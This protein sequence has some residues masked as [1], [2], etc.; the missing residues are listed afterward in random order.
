VKLQEAILKNLKKARL[1]GSKAKTLA[2]ITAK[3]RTKSRI[4]SIAKSIK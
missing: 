4:E 3:D 1:R 2:D